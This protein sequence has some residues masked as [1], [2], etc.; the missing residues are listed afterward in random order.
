MFTERLW[1]QQVCRPAL[2]T[3]NAALAAL[4][5]PSNNRLEY[6]EVWTG[7]LLPHDPIQP[8]PG[9]KA[10]VRATPA[11]LELVNLE[12]RL[13]DACRR[14]SRLTDLFVH[15]QGSASTTRELQNCRAVV[16]FWGRG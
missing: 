8:R 14:R 12:K 4:L 7:S 16:V 6:P 1:Y 15:L 5:L 3:L 10:A 2:C 13:V 9:S 11:M